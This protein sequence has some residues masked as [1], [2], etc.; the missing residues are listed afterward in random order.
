MGSDMSQALRNSSQCQGKKM[1]VLVLLALKVKGI[2]QTPFPWLSKLELMISHCGYIN[3]NVVN[4]TTI[5]CLSKIPGPSL[6]VYL[7]RRKPYT[8]WQCIHNMA[9]SLF[10]FLCDHL[11]LSPPLSH[12]LWVLRVPQALLQTPPGA[13][14]HPTTDKQANVKWQGVQLTKPSMA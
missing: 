14:F 9:L 5:V 11:S 10:P 1:S 13:H 8:R 12:L 6:T 7:L 3:S 2:H 4:G